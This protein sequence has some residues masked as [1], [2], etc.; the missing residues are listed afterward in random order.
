VVTLFNL[1][2]LVVRVFEFPSLNARWD[3]DAYGSITWALMLLHTTHLITD[4]AGTLVITVFLFTHP[5]RTER[6]SDVD[7]DCLYWLFVVMA[8]LPIYAA[9]YWAPRLV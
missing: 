1:A 4:A 2:A 7:D 3:V 9:V 6:F 8:W 5:V